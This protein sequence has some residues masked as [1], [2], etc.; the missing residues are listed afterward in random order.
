MIMFAKI[1]LLI[2]L[3]GMQNAMAIEDEDAAAKKKRAAEWGYTGKIS[4]ENWGNLHPTFELCSNGK[5][6]SPIDVKFVEL[7]R[8]PRLQFNYDTTT[9]EVSNDTLGSKKFNMGKYLSIDS[10]NTVQLDVAD[11]S[12]EESI[13]LNGVKYRLI[14]QHFHRPAEHLIA[15]KRY[16]LEIHFVHENDKG[17]LA[18]IGVFV[19]EGKNINTGIKAILDPL[20]AASAGNIIKSEIKLSPLWLIPGRKTFYEYAGS[21]T[22][23]PCGE[24]VNWLLMSAPIEATADQIKEFGKLIPEANSRPIQPLKDRTIKEF[25]A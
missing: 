8:A 11:G 16:P 17:Q 9:L 23:P 13:M 2:L 14:E 6:Q 18:V 20:S 19:E 5:E 22:T 7:T 25:L 3:A 10:G 24:G 4:A 21:L 1:C 15:G 12:R